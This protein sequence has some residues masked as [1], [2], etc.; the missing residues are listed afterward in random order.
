MKTPRLPDNEQ[1]RLAALASYDILDSQ[2]DPALDAL[3]R[4]A[5]HI[6][7]VPIAL[8]SL[9][10][11]D[12][13]YFVSR[14]GLEV[15][16]THRDISFCGHVV[17]DG[18]PLIVEDA[19]KDERFS[20]NPL[21][22]GEPRIRFYAGF[23]L[24]TPDGFVLGTL[25][26]IDPRPR[27]PSRDDLELLDLLARQALDQLEL[28]RKT[29]L[30]NEQERRLRAILETATDV[31]IMIDE[32]G[33]I[34]QVNNAVELQFGYSSEE[35]V[36]QN[37]RLLMPASMRSAHDR[38]IAT[39]LR[40][41]QR[42]VIG[43]PR[44]LVAM[45]KDGT[46]FPIDAMVSEM[47]L[48]EQRKFTGIL[49]DATD[50]KNIE[51]EL[52]ATLSEL[53][54]S[55]DIQNQVL[56]A[57]GIGVLVLEADHSVAFANDSFL[58][59]CGREAES[60]VG[61][62]WMEVLGTNAT[63]RQAIR[64][65]RTLPDLER[66]RVALRLGTTGN[67]QRYVDLDLRDYPG[68]SARQIMF[69]Y[70][71]TDVHE[72]RDQLGK[73]SGEQMIGQS[74]AIRDLFNQIDQVAQGDWTVLVEG[75]TGAG[76]ELAARAI[77]GASERR[78]QPFIAVNCAGLTDSL[79][80]SQLFGH[81]KGAFT[82]A[83]VAREGLF[84]AAEGGSLFL[85]EIGDVSATV[86]ASLLRVLQEKEITRLGETGIRKVNVRIITASNRNLQQ[87]VERGQFRED[88]LYRI[89]IARVRVPPLR[90]RREDIPLL[91]AAFLAQQRIASGKL[92]VD[93][94]PDVLD[95]MVH[96]DWPGNIRELKSAIE[97]GLMRCRSRRIELA[98]LPP[99]ILQS[100][101]LG[102][103]LPTIGD[104]RTRIVHALRATKGNRARAAR[105]LGVGRATLYRRLKEFGI[106]H[107]DKDE[108]S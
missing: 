71:V 45:R 95:R 73:Q 36:G 64:A 11:A 29:V 105:L 101:R 42:R 19:S 106:R 94:S 100:E 28:R 60:V 17:G 46:T 72:L 104:E 88:L 10:D 34:E 6:L 13:Q 44:E 20:D 87:L 81:A 66:T 14:Y 93:I 102:P 54:V 75:E 69:L 48:G 56:D 50:R 24:R 86:Q 65:L 5:A 82:G 67:G 89:R 43:I 4:V 97:H 30:L 68:D 70:D 47:R 35:L 78:Q 2:A 61:K 31:I 16:E 49:R 107:Q 108:P 63:E 99:E 26:A 92:V 8:V 9:V 7:K 55:H 38:G 96:Y 25:C 40:T 53:R 77:H 22:T 85:D 74:Q 90:E 83:D 58:S 27:A 84:E 41:G 32:D 76:K 80:G 51:E 15:S 59:L 62:P 18:S 79:L 12:R 57:L 91:A 21:V 1:E 98:D 39:Y 23:P 52:S 37:I 33:R 3:T 103:S